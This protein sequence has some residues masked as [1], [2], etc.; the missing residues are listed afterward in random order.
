MSSGRA[1]PSCRGSERE[2]YKNCCQ[3]S[4]EKINDHLQEVDF[5]VERRPCSY[6]GTVHYSYLCT[7]QLD[8]PANPNQPGP[9]YFKT[10]RKCAIFGISCEAI[11]KQVNFLIDEGLLTGKRANGTIS[12]VHYFFWRHGLGETEARTSCRQLRHSK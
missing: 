4:K 7:Q 6:T 9:I 11:P 3:K 10:P 2:F 8:F 1:P 12:Y 5:S